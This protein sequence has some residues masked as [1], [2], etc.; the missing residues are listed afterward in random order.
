M[1]KLTIQD[2]ALFIGANAEHEI[3]GVMPISTKWLFDIEDSMGEDVDFEMKL[4]KPILSPL[5]DLKEQQA[6]EIA[7]IIY[8]QPD[9]VKWRVEA[10]KY[11]KCFLIYRKH[12]SKRFTIC[13]ESG[14]I[15]CYEMDGVDEPKDIYMNQHFVTKYLI[16][17]HFDI[18]GWIEKGLA[19]SKTKN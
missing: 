4:I 13:L 6:I 1:E 2:L 10:N 19:I 15:E 11:K 14:E 8:G 9:S 17:K 3:L 12:Y 5:S 16:S 18:F 7:T